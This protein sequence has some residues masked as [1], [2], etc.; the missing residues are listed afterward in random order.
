MIL[1]RTL[2]ADAVDDGQRLDRVVATHCPDAARAQIL[3]AIEEGAITRNGRRA[4]KGARVAAGDSIL[5]SRLL[6]RTDHRAQA[7]PSMPLA[8]LYEDGAILALDKPAGIPTH[9]LRSDETGTLTNALL[10]HDPALA[11]I[12]D[13][14]LFPSLVHRLDTDTSGVVLAARTPRAY[15]FLRDAFRA[16]RVSKQYLALVRGSPPHH[17]R[18]ENMLAHDP[19]RP[20]HMLVFTELPD[21]PPRRPMRAITQYESATRFRTHTLL[22]VVI[23]TGVTHQ[24]R[25][26]LAATGHPIAGDPLYGGS[27]A[28]G[29]L[30]LQRQFLHAASIAFEHPETHAPLQIESPLPP[31]LAAVLAT[32][33]AQDAPDHR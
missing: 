30:G 21:P 24:I 16:H 18:L 1:E 27:I 3:A 8:I 33:A 29:E 22:R 11:A 2:V 9:P 28:S 19:S 20:G 7:D 5:I 4:A 15:T 14:P 26:Q 23:P 10:A 32:L 13:D 25:A 12:G 31:D 6:E 17:G